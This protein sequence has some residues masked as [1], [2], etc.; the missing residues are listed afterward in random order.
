MTKLTN[1]EWAEIYHQLAHL[2]A[3]NKE[4]E[5]KGFLDALALILGG[6][7]AEKIVETVEQYIAD[8]KAAYETEAA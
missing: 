6:D 7:G 1:S 5:K 4:A 3:A 2:I 8:E